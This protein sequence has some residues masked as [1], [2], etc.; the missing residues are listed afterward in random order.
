MWHGDPE[1]YDRALRDAGGTLERLAHATRWRWQEAWR[2]VFARP[3]HEAT[4]RWRVDD[5]D[6]SVFSLD[7]VRSLKGARALQAGADAMAAE[8]IVM[9]DA[10]A[11]PAFLLRGSRMPD[12][13]LSR[14]DAWIAPTDLAWT[15]AFTHE[16]GALLPGPYFSRREWI[17]SA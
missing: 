15:L 14:I 12:L 8:L 4:G 16:D 2:A 7:T 10:D 6:W 3:L 11:L 9:P 5:H 17:V 13:G 1:A